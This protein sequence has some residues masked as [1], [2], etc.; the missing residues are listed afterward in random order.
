MATMSDADQ[1]VAIRAALHKM[2]D[3][4]GATANLNLADAKAAL[5]Y[6]DRFMQGD[7]VAT[8]TTATEIDVTKTVAV[9]LNANLPEPFKS[10]ATLAQKG[11]LMAYWAMKFAGVI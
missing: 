4:A 11:L 2:Y 1:Y 5:A 9:N 7:T 8:L 6:I 3:E 10:N